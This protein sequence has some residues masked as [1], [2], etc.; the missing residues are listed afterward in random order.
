MKRLAK[1]NH[2][3]DWRKFRGLKQEQLAEAAG[4]TK[5]TISRIEAGKVGL[6]QKW[7]ETLAPL[8]DTTPAGLLTPPAAA[9]E[10]ADTIRRDAF[11][12]L[13]DSVRAGRWTEVVDAYPKGHED[14]L[15]P[16]LRKYGPRAF[17][18][19]LKGPSMRPDYHEDDIVVFDPDIEARPGDDVVARQDEDNEATFKRLRIK[20]YDTKG[21]PQIE[22]VPLNPDWPVLTLKKGGR[23]VAPA[24]DL[25]RRLRR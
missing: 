16:V 24:V 19:R 11:V 3:S 25:I 5:A 1:R 7:L 9:S 14:Q 15:I 10:S 6:S 8:L 12:P 13:I 18:L 2:L 17:A 4:T 20:G 23:I 22:L 21:K